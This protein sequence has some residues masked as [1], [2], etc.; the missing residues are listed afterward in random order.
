MKLFK[1]EIDNGSAYDWFAAADA[2][3]ARAN[4]DSWLKSNGYTPDEEEMRT[5]NVVECQPDE[6]FTM[7]GD[8]EGDGTRT[9]T[10]AEWMAE[11]ERQQFVDGYFASSEW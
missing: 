6:S 1:L 11:F 10:V 8:Y 5:T 4:R 3:T 2:E 7:H 9:Q